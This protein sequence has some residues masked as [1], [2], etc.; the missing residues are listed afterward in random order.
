[1]ARETEDDLGE[2]VELLPPEYSR[3]A[4]LVSFHVALVPK[5]SGNRMLK[6]LQSKLP[7]GPDL[8]HLKRA[9]SEKGSGSAGHLEVLVCPEGAEPPT[10]VKALVD[11]D[12]ASGATWQVAKVPQHSALTRAQLAEWSQY[13]PLTFRKPS[14]EPLELPTELVE[15]YTALLRRAQEL[16]AATGG[17]CACVIVDRDGRELAATTDTSAPDRPLRH[18]VMSGIEAIADARVAASA[19]AGTKRAI[20]DDEHLCCDCEVVTTHEP[21]L[22]C[23][24]ALVHSRVKT[25]VYLRPDPEFGG[26]GGKVSLHTCSSL[27]HQFRVLTWRRAGSQFCKVQPT[28][29][30]TL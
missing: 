9:R 8:I 27:N 4:S 20:A 7:L 11:E 3:G 1:M 28:S 17:R 12:A 13:W 25:V 6:L 26:L 15:R 29:A 18:A 23:A 16:S 22:M 19:K 21:C 10:E 30:G 14:L 24:M 5:S 2:M